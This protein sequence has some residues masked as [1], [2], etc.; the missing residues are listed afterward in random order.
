MA[1]TG[2]GE[3]AAACRTKQQ[4]HEEEKR[5]QLHQQH[6]SSTTHFTGEKEKLKGRALAEQDFLFFFL[7][8]FSSTCRN[9]YMIVLQHQSNGVVAI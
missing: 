8:F 9:G 2:A 4:E 5:H 6:R 3:K 1:A 7:V